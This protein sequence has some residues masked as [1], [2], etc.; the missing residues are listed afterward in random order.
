MKDFRIVTAKVILPIYSVAPVRGFLPLSI[1]VIGDRLDR[2]VEVLYNGISVSEFTA[3]APNRLLVKVPS[4]QIG[5]KFQDLKVLSTVSM[6]KADAMLSLGVTTPPKTVAGIDRLVQS[7]VLIFLTTPGS[8]IF[9]PN[10]GGGAIAIVG[11]PT[12]RSGKGVAADLA[13]A[14]ERT[15]QEILRLQAGSQVIPPSEKLLSCTLDS[16]QYDHASTVTSARV[17]IQNMLGN[18]AEVSLG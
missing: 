9:T 12:D 14:I 8:D 10:S 18:A 17:N 15:K 16:V 3:L 11:R 7:W 2:A 13:I 5:Q 4:S 1:L 6:A